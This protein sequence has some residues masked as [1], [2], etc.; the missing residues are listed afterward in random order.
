MCAVKDYKRWMPVKQK[1]NNVPKQIHFKERD[2]FWVS[3]GENVGC[4]EDGKGLLFNRPVL[5]VRKFNNYLFW[6]AALSTTQKRGQYYHA[7]LVGNKISVALL[8]QTHTY[9][10]SRISA[11][12]I[13]VISQED[14]VS[15]KQKLALVLLG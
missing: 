8:S 10:A 6:G 12:K 3:I 4:E 5:V 7:F 11:N 1:L 13:G 14:F 2:I 15:L 9:S